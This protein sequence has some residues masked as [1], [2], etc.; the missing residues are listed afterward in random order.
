MTTTK[1]V[2]SVRLGWID[3]MRGAA[4]VL[5]VL[6]HS[7]LYVGHHTPAPEFVW[8]LNN[9]VAPVRMPAMMLLSGWLVER[10]LAKGF[11][12]YVD[13]KL[14]NLVHPFLVW[15]PLLIG[16]HMVLHPDEAG[17]SL[18]IGALTEPVAHL[19]F[20]SYLTVYY[21]IALL[22]RAIPAWAVTGVVFVAAAARDAGSDDRGLYLLG[23]F[24]LGVWLGRNGSKVERVLSHPLAAVPAVIGLWWLYR[25]ASEHGSTLYDTDHL[26]VALLGIAAVAW[27]FH[28]VGST[29]VAAPLRHIGRYSLIYYLASWPAGL[30]ADR[31]IELSGVAVP[32]AVFVCT[33]AGL[34]GGLVVLTVVERVH[35]VGYLFSARPRFAAAPARRG[36]RS[37][38]PG[39]SAEPSST[40]SSPRS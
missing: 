39:R 32:G 17:W 15:T 27:V 33:A 35:L 1:P 34:L 18:V 37:W 19:W 13:G 40:E 26:A 28:R 6:Y 30:F 22:T 14:V 7:T 8:D 2:R 5:V 4:I 9:T 29:V 38:W 23:F 25:T 11:R 31:M 24:M 16:L 12:R 21:G 3:A 20:L 10:S 36:E